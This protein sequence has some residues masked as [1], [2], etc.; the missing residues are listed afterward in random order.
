MSQN[1][2]QQSQQPVQTTGHVWDG[3]LQEF[4]NPLPTWWVYT[5]FATVVFAVGYWLIYPAWPIGD[6]F[7][8]GFDTITYVDNS[9]KK[10]TT[11]WN[12]RALYM[13]DMNKAAA[14]Q[15][16]FFD[17]VMATP[18]EQI[19]KD[20]ELENFVMATGH[21]L[22]EN[23]CASCHQT[24]GQGLVGHYPNLTDDDWLYG[25]HYAQINYTVTHGRHGYMPTFGEVLEP[26]QIDDLA[27]YVASLSGIPADPAKVAAGKQLFHSNTA[28]CFYC[29]GEQATGR[30]VIGAP[31]LTDQIWLWADVPA[32][33][34]AQGKIE[35]IRQVIYN[36]V[37]KGVMPAWGDRLSAVDIKVLTFY[38][39]N[40]GGG[41]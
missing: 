36:G 18:Y 3:D 13:E 31:N 10:V 28:G 39:H 17:K 1:P 8:K 16:P 7:T 30:H 35:A 20:P 26:A 21:S 4:N 22:F 24:G 15:K 32:H 37:N 2:S 33:H 29:H 38:I 25:G 12:T 14:F 27:N 9:G 5:F 40:L 23:N 11:H 41:Q 6:S 19:A 34:S